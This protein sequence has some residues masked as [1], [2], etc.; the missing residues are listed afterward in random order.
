VIF[1]RPLSRFAT[2]I[3]VTAAV[4]LATASCEKP[5][6]G[7]GSPVASVQVTPTSA[8]I[9][10][11]Q[12]T[13]LTATLKDRKGKTLS[14]RAVAWSSS[15]TAVATVD[16]YGVVSGATAGAAK[17]IATC[18]GQ[19]GYA[20]IA[21]TDVSVASVQ[22][23]PASGSLEVGQTLQLTATPKDA[24]GNPL[25]GRTVTWSSSNG[26]VATVDANG[27]VSGVTA[28]PATITAT[29]GTKS[30]SAAI[31]VTQV[32]VASVDVAPASGSI[33]IGQTIQLTATPKDASGNPLSGR[34]VT[35]SSSNSAVAT[36][37]ANG[38]VSG[39]TAGAATIT[40]TSDGHSGTADITV[41]E[42]P[43]SSVEI[44]PGSATIEVGQTAQLTATPRDAN[45]NPLSGR[46]VTWSSSNTSVATVDQ[47][48]LVTGVG[49]GMA[50]IVAESEGASGAILVEVIDAPVASVEVT[51]ASANVEVSHTLQLTATLKDANGNPLSGRTVTWSSSNPSLA[52]VNASGWV[53]GKAV[54]PVT[55][56]ATSEGQSGTAD[57]TVT[58]HE[59]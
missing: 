20:D 33:E 19:S 42:A 9:T 21:V 41:T 58:P 3:A 46:T 34:T 54:G 44:T 51:P 8:G 50:V 45:G 36:V 6:T 12:T 29:S 22:V 37:D 53:T 40:A 35:W 11:G 17:I 10:A 14:G 47:T 52:T 23:T 32:P 2:L 18:E 49:A 7:P 39:V 57:I 16:A 43:V 56:T 59:H 38:L 28:G 26:A 13:P 31:T 24:S 55:I 27:R 30:G 15:N 5:I 4:A 25:P 48:G 1:K